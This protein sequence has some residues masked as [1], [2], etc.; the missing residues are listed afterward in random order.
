MKVTVESVPAK[1]LAGDLRLS[2]RCKGS[3][4]AVLLT[5]E[6]AQVIGY[7]LCAVARE[8]TLWHSE[9]D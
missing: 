2:V 6:E 1:G 3:S 4:I 7:A 5:V 8:E 9:R